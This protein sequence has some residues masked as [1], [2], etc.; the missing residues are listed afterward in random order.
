[1]AFLWETSVTDLPIDRIGQA[2]QKPHYRHRRL[3]RARTPHL[4]REQQ[5]APAD[6]GNE[7]T[8]LWVE[9]GDFLPYALLAPPTGPFGRFTARSACLRAEV[10][11][12]GQT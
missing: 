7:L 3:L 1:V 5:T 11:S 6:Q 9:H 8:P 4:G 12:L 2:V 10:R